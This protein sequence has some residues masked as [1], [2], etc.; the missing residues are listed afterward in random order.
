MNGN[1]MH[2]IYI[3]VHGW[4]FA[5]CDHKQDLFCTMYFLQILHNHLFCDMTHMNAKS[6]FLLLLE[7]F[8]QVSIT[9]LICSMNFQFKF[10]DLMH[11][12]LQC[13]T[14]YCCQFAVIWFGQR[15]HNV[16]QCY[17]YSLGISVIILSYMVLCRRVYML[18]SEQD[19]D[20]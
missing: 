9:V 15:M 13:N 1:T 19:P 11:Q 7:L 10:I 20:I 14:F 4:P 6:L 16:N 3:Y 18:L 8:R 5:L 2:L 12:Q 17:R